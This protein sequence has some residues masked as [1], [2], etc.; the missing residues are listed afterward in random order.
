MTIPSNNLIKKSLYE[1]GEIPPLGHVP[2]YMHAWVI[3]R[4]RHGPPIESFKPEIVETHT[5]G[6]SEVLIM[7]NGCRC[8]L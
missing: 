2:D 1:V 6:R 8:K 4:E 5:I 7:V 3:R